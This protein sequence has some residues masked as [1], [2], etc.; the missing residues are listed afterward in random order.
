MAFL[1]FSNDNNALAALTSEKRIKPAKPV[2]HS[3]FYKN[4]ISDSTFESM[5]KASQ[6]TASD[7]SRQPQNNPNVDK[8]GN[9]YMDQKN[10]NHSVEHQQENSYKDDPSLHRGIKEIGKHS[11]SEIS[12]KESTEHESEKNQSARSENESKTKTEDTGIQKIRH[13]EEKTASKKPTKNDE[14]NS[15][16]ENLNTRENRNASAKNIIDLKDPEKISLLTSSQNQKTE[17]I[18]HN[19]K[20]QKTGINQKSDKSDLAKISKNAD[21]RDSSFSDSGNSKENRLTEKTI[22]H[23]DS[24]TTVKEKLSEQLAQKVKEALDSKDNSIKNK[25]DHIKLK[26]HKTNVSRETITQ[27]AD[28]P[29]IKTEGS[30]SRLTARQNNETNMQTAL[31]K[32]KGSSFGKANSESQSE[33]NSK[34]FDHSSDFSAA[35]LKGEIKNDSSLRFSNR[36]NMENLRAQVNEKVQSLLNRSKVL[37]KDSKNASLDA[38][39]YPKELGKISLKL[40]LIEGNIQGR[41]IV[42]NEII[43]KELNNRLNQIAQELKEMGHEISGFEVNVRSSSKDN[44]QKNGFSSD[45]FNKNSASSKIYTANQSSVNKAGIES[46]TEGIYA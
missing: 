13:E 33:S 10:L 36:M 42:D 5:L 3:N 22:P 8:E 19:A 18:E 34:S 32:L 37:I 46:T 7:Y 26:S 29:A 21:S 1:H 39:L 2:L 6:N 14:S 45:D 27:R 40:S 15:E 25:Y 12:S 17:N 35:N 30:T 38:Q 31:N 41:F 11:Q 28:S 20:N 44:N 23:R 24:A 4:N 16:A 9:H 43:Q